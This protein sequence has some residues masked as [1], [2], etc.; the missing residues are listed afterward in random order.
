MGLYNVLLLAK[1]VL[2]IIIHN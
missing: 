1:L 2:V